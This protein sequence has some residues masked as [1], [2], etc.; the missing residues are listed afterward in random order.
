MSRQA[1][2]QLKITPEATG[3][4]HHLGCLVPTWARTQHSK[5]SWSHIP[6]T[7][8]A[9]LRCLNKRR[10]LLDGPRERMHR[11]AQGKYVGRLRTGDI[12]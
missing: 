7:S 2:A 12:L 10:N 11:I 6:A 8:L 1:P 9:L 5:K 3:G 4:H